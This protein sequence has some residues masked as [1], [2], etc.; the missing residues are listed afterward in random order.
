M[1]TV[2]TYSNGATEAAQIPGASYYASIHP[3]I[4]AEGSQE[5]HLPCKVV[6][7]QAGSNRSW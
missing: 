1:A 3:S 7:N 5:P 6:S 2:A 4:H